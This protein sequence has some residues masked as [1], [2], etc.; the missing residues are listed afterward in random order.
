MSD[1]PPTDNSGRLRLSPLKRQSNPSKASGIQSKYERAI[2]KK[3]N[4]L[5]EKQQYQVNSPFLKKVC[6]IQRYSAN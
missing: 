5:L 6:S 3:S 4:M 2:T 1:I